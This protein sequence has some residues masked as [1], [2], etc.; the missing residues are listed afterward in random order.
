MAEPNDSPGKMPLT[1]WQRA[2]LILKVVEVRL[3]FIAILVVT[4]LVIGYWD[5]IKNHWDKW[6]RPAAPVGAVQSDTEFYCPMHP[7]VVR[8]GLEDGQVPKCPICGMPLS[9][10]K[11]GEAPALPAGV[12][13]RVQLTPE[14]IE[15]AG[16]LTEE[17]G[18]KRLEKEIVTVGSVQYDETRLSRIV[19]R[20]SGYLEKLLVSET[21]VDVKEGEPLAEIYSP[22]LYAAA[23][24]LVIARKS[25]GMSELVKAGREKLTLLGL[26][27]REIDRILESGDPSSRLVIRSPQH[28]HVIQR[29]VVK[30]AYVSVG[31]TLFEVA[32]LTRIWIEADVFEGDIPFLRKGQDI[33]ATVEAFPNRVFK[34]TVA[35]VHP[36]LDPSSRTNTVRF[37]L[38]NPKHDLRPGMYAT[39]KIRTPLGEI[40]P[41]KTLLASVASIGSESGSNAG[42]RRTIWWCPMHP[43]VRSSEPGGKCEKCGGMKLVP[44]VVPVPRPGDVLAIPER[45]V[46]D[47]GS[48]KIVYVER[49]PGIFEG[50]LVELGPRVGRDFPVVKG[51]EAGERIATAGSFLIDA[52]TRLN[53]AAAS[54]YVG[55]SGGPSTGHE[56]PPNAPPPKKADPPGS[57]ASRA[58]GVES[59]S[60]SPEDRKLA[61]AQGVCPITGEPLGSMGTP[62]KV[63]LDGHPVF[64]CCE[65]CEEDAK[66][67]PKK[68]LEKASR[69]GGR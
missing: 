56:A 2:G 3:R 69:G 44:R 41:F 61:E 66:R 24:E 28:G 38:E 17:V 53:P 18:Y 33:E 50:V 47:T 58:I 63:V 26:D 15:L 62:D 14:R 64:L 57:N 31:M 36:H 34:G 1:P 59:W 16:V 60:L 21:F 46:I 12:T 32:D 35:L 45:S 5:T 37:T 10:R 8:P 20:V 54:T 27:E 4:G 22:E 23:R 29:N 7:S 39:V 49:E 67:D 48:R 11:K 19:A 43:E 55:A 68:T 65:G 30:G 40:E 52:E 9:L 25:A 42:D 51:L 6:T 13:G